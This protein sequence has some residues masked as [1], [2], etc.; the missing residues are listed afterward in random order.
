MKRSSSVRERNLF[1]HFAS[2]ARYLRG[3]DLLALR[4]VECDVRHLPGAARSGAAV[5]SRIARIPRPHRQGQRPSRWVSL[6]CANGGVVRGPLQTGLR[7]HEG[8]PHQSKVTMMPTL[9]TSP[10]MSHS[11]APSTSPM[12]MPMN[13]GRKRTYPL[14]PE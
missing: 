9:V 4:S 10:T 7:G 5:G 12:M 2:L 14:R 13:S 1:P 6:R 8:E 3:E 11:S